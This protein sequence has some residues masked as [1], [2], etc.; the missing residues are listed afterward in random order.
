MIGAFANINMAQQ[1]YRD[2]KMFLSPTDIFTYIL[3][4]MSAGSFIFLFLRFLGAELPFRPLIDLFVCM[5]AVAAIYL[6]KH[7]QL[8]I[9]TLI[10]PFKGEVSLYSF[11]IS[12]SNKVLGIV[13]VPLVFL[14]AYVP[15]MLQ[16]SFLWFTL[17]VLGLA[18]LYR[19]FRGLIISGNYLLYNKF[20]FLLYLCAV[21]IAPILLLVKIILKG[22]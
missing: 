12:N 2:Q 5:S 3:F 6:L 11:I 4:F 21:E 20:H 7:L 17:G 16:S 13:L 14:S 8:F 19:S 18:Y 22:A 1:A 15:T 10:F 9:L